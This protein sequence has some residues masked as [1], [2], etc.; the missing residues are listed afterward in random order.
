MESARKIHISIPPIVVP[1]ATRARRTE[2]YILAMIDEGYLRINNKG[3]VYNTFT[4]RFIGLCRSD[5]NYPKV[6]VY[7]PVEKKNHSIGLHVLV[8][9][10]FIGNIPKGMIVNH[11]NGKK[12]D[13]RHTNLELIT[14]AENVQHAYDTGLI[15]AAWGEAHGHALFTNREVSKYRRICNINITDKYERRQEII[16]IAE[17]H[18]TSLSQVYLMLRGATYNEVGGAV[19]RTQVITDEHIEQCR[20]LRS[21]GMTYR[22][23]ADKLGIDHKSVVKYAG[24][25]KSV[26]HP[27]NKRAQQTAKNKAA[28]KRTPHRKADSTPILARKNKTS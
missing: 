16:K 19:C 8:Y 4:D 12:R 14:Q 17:R 25:G 1:K 6:S 11:K 27:Y 28:R 9:L 26:R 21:S 3:T 5:K 23:I 24:D 7:D 10:V 13:S 2:Q 20:R 15:K 22:S 18:N